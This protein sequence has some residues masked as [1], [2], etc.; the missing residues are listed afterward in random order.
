M[1]IIKQLKNARLALGMK[2]AELGKKI[3]LP[4][5]HVSKIEQGDTNPR[6]STV[7]DWAEALDQKLMLIPRQEVPYIEALLGREEDTEE[8][9]W[10]PDEKIEK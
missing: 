9:R 1:S 3:G 10:Q 5:S 8:R 7:V 2:Q 4:Q 6:L